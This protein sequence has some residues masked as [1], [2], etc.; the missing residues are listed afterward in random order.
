MKNLTKAQ[1]F[2][3]SEAMSQ[4]D[5]A[6]LL[7]VNRSTVSRRAVYWNT[8]ESGK[9]ILHSRNTLIGLVEV[10]DKIMDGWNWNP[11]APGGDEFMEL[12]KCVNDE[13]R[14]VLSGRK[15]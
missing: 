4:S 3:Q 11:S 7:G 15:K 5:V 6:R 9:I 12:Y 14:A 10:M 1:V 8:N 2:K 13:T